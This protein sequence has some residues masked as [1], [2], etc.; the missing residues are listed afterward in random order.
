MLELAGHARSDLD[1]RLGEVDVAIRPLS[2][3]SLGLIPMILAVA[4]CSATSSPVPAATT[5]PSSGA[6]SVQVTPASSPSAPAA[7]AASPT[8]ASPTTAPSAPASQGPASAHFVLAGSASQSGPIRNAGVTCDEPTLEG[9][10]IFLTGQSG[11]A[12]PNVVIFLRSGYVLVRVATGSAAALRERD[13]T[14]SGVTNFDPAS[15][16]QLNSPLTE[17]T[18]PGAKIGTLGALTSISGTISCGNEE[19]GSA[20]LMITGTSAE[21]PL[22]GSLTNVEVSCSGSG[23][24]TF[25]LTR[26][27]TTAGTTP[28][29]VFVDSST[30]QLRATVETEAASESYAGS[31]ASFVT[32]G[33]GTIHL[34]GS[35]TAPVASGSTTPADKLQISGDAT[36]G[37]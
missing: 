10:Q 28:V 14:G 32:F 17:I 8:T 37:R 33:P 15:G 20:S 11:K 23:A 13:F 16:A 3:A 31:G 35:V 27:L 4:A 30:G 2:R 19:P 26:G 29:L 6:P 25:G 7:A 5:A 9:P 36:C 12:G 22:N 18:A 1:E 21:G 34:D 24:S